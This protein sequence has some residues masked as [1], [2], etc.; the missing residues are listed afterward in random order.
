MKPVGLAA[1]Q[2]ICGRITAKSE[3]HA[4]VFPPGKQAWIILFPY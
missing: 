4:A 3:D 1:Y 2:V